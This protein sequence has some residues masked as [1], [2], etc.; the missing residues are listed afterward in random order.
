MSYE[1]MPPPVSNSISQ[2]P[3]HVGGV[4]L[5]IVMS[6][7]TSSGVRFPDKFVCAR[8]DGGGLREEEFGGQLV[9]GARDCLI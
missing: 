3:V 1:E 2:R 8:G 9:P 4:H 5:V 7:S 6:T